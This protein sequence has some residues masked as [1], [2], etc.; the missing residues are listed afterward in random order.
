VVLHI[1]M[2]EAQSLTDLEVCERWHKLYKGTRL[3]QK[4]IKGELLDEAQI[5]AVKK[6]WTTGG[7]N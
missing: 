6:N 1:N 3:T 5:L 7:L 2:P 4:C